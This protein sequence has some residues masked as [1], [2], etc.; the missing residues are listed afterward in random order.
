MYSN[1]YFSR[2]KSLIHYWEYDESGEKKHN[3]APAPLYFYTK[4]PTGTYKT[5][6]GDN[7]KR[8]DCDNLT[9]YKERTERYKEMGMGLFE[10]DI[11]VETKFIVNNYLGK[12]LKVPK[13]DIHFLDIEVH[14][15]EGFPKPEDANFPIVIITVWSTK[16]NK[17]FVFTEKDFDTTK[18]EKEHNE[19]FVKYVHPKEEDLL[20]CFIS[21]VHNEHPD[22]ITGWSS[23]SFDIPYIINRSKKVLGERA[24]AKL[25]PVLAIKEREFHVS[26]IK[27]EKRYEIAGISTLDLLEVYQNYTFSD[28]ENYKLGY[29]TKLELG[30]EVTK[31]EYNGS[32]ADFYNN[33]WQGYAEY[34]I[35]DTRLLRFLEDKL[36]YLKMLVN[37]CYGCRI[38]FDF[39]QKTTKILDGAFISELAK[40]GIVLPD[41]NR[42]LIK[43]TYPGGYVKEPLGG[44]HDWVVSFDA[45]SLYPSIMMGW[46]ISP[47]TKVAVINK[48]KINNI[49]KAFDNLPC[50]E[51]EVTYKGKKMSLTEFMEH[52]KLVGIKK[53]NEA[54]GFHTIVNGAVV[55]NISRCIAGKDY[56]NISFF[57][58]DEET[59]VNNAVETIKKENYCLATNG[60]IYSQNVK[61]VIPRFVETWFNERNKY[62]KLMLVAE[63]N[64][65]K[66]DIKYYHLLQLN[67]KILI[68]SV[69]GYLGT[70][71]SRFYDY[72]N[73]V[74][75]TITGQSI[76]KQCGNSTESYFSKWS[77]TDLGRKYNAKDIKNFVIYND[78]DSIYL[79][80]GKLFESIGYDYRNKKIEHVKN[81]IM[82]G[83]ECDNE[84][85][86]G[87]QIDKKQVGGWDKSKRDEVENS[88]KS[89]Q[90]LIA[91]FI[92][93][94]MGKL[95]TSLNCKQNRISFKREAIA[96]RAIFL[97]PKKYVYWVLNSE[98]V[99]M[100]KMKAVGVEIVRSSTPILVQ[101]HLKN[102]IF[103][104]LRKSD[105]L[106]AEAQIREFREKFFAASPEA[107][108]FPKTVNN[109]DTYGEKIDNGTAKSIPIHV[110][111]ARVYNDAIG[112]NPKLRK[113]YDYIYEADKMKFVYMKTNATCQENVLGFKDKW[114]V[115]LNLESYIDYE[116]QFRKTFLGP[117][118][119][120]YG[121]LNWNMPNLE[122]KNVQSLF[123]W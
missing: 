27:I 74:A 61:G 122:N 69:Y 121:L 2:R 1:V 32:L 38:P 98:G 106:H 15:E 100:D 71:H 91:T 10:S 78:T 19:V 11:P 25:S 6:F 105:P 118:E 26:E 96:V 64:N 24:T 93:K 7:A 89:L 114:P 44:V 52:V 72:D 9:E 62:K 102:I 120:F 70:V 43:G 28:R 92:S 73:A 75:V 116:L 33:D 48:D 12:E 20:K 88:C 18:L 8:I 112:N 109:L 16:H 123:E 55:D 22:I 36:G 84:E 108:A 45:T 115:E 58:N 117:I 57:W 95:T 47:E 87:Q 66:D 30:E 29:I 101:K 80:F 110:R 37:F 76:I 23:N 53:I 51:D 97:E 107:I 17:F 56:E 68:N 35:Q 50:Y 54:G 99:E 81:Y 49:L 83:K 79:S 13:F 119:R 46:N 90:N 65:K 21:F 86:F 41:V 94:Q 4:S 60:V 31:K 67:Y 34:N 111:A 77:G 104:I 3:T 14:S 39:Y 59:D 40:D 113:I 82:F 42:D 63:D 5:I 103:D 85:I